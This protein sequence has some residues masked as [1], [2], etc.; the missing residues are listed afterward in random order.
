VAMELDGDDWAPCSHW[1]ELPKPP[2]P[3]Y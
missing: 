2:G 3:E 1:I